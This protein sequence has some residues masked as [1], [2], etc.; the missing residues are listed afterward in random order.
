MTA[1]VEEGIP[2]GE[3]LSRRARTDPSQIA[4]TM[5][6]AAG[7]ETDYAGALIGL[8][9]PNSVEFIAARA[10][11]CGDRRIHVLDDHSRFGVLGDHR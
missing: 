3:Q 2:F 11:G 1:A 6:S 10:P 7:V 9:I 5:V 8:A 4:V